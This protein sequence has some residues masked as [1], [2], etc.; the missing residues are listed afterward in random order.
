MRPLWVLAEEGTFLNHGSFGACPRVVLAAQAR[1]REAMESQPDQFFRS[2]I[3]PGEGVT[4]LRTAASDLAA[5][6]NAGHDQLAFIENATAG[7]QA[8]LRSVDFAPGDRILITD[9]TYNAVRLMVEARCA[10]TGATP[11]VVRIPIPTSADAIMAR[12][13]EALTAR[14]KLAVIDHITSPTALVMPLDRVVPELR[15]AGALVLV[16]GAHAVGQIALDIRSLEVDWYVS[17]MHKWLFAPKGS[18]FLY[19]SRDVAARTRPNV[20]SHFI[21]LGFPQAFDFTGTRDNSAWL[22]VPAAIRFFEELDPA[23]VRRYQARLLR[24]CSDLLLSVGARVVG[25]TD[26]CAAM[27]SFVLPQARPATQTDADEVMR[28]LWEK[29]RIQTMAKELGGELLLR[30]SAQVYVDEGDMH[31]LSDALDRRGWPGR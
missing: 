11:L 19:A 31:R 18:A 3:M 15:K 9:H 6:V 30:V 24:I 21:A 20:V 29:D 4:T 8:V 1:I 28:V 14:V 13:A 27:R 22:S 2:G 7:V 17:N 10:Q 25:P 5:F 23:A 12:F 16:D 26:M